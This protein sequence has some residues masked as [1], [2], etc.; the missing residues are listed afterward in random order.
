MKTDLDINYYYNWFLDYTN[1]FKLDD[2]GHQKNIELK[3]IH[4]QKVKEE[5][6]ALGKSINLDENN[7]F[8]AELIGLFHDIGRFKQYHEYKT[9]N[10]KISVNH[11]ELGIEIL[12]ENII[13][14]N[15]QPGTISLIYDAIENHNKINLPDIKSDKLLLFSQLIRDADKIDIFRVMFEYYNSTE[16]NDTVVLNL[17]DKESF[18]TE[19]FNKFLNKEKIDYSN[20]KTINDFKLLKINWIYD[21]NFSHSVKTIIERKYIKYLIDSMP[22]N[23]QTEII[24]EK[25][26]IYLNEKFLISV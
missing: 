8:I 1:T 12:K 2:V 18:T 16:Y 7:L 26:N 20:L 5:I 24:L 9:F 23:K 6:T 14:K 13:L 19:I 25:I 22:K 15:L 17:K 10:D 21:L 3:I 11:A 4:S